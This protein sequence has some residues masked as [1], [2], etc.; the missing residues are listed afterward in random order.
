MVV[1]GIIPFL[2]YISILTNILLIW[3]VMKKTDEMSTLREDT[4]TIFETVEQFSDHLDNLHELETFYGD[5]NL[6]SL[7]THSREV[8]NNIIDVQE[9]YYDDVETTL[10]TYDEEESTEEKE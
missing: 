6:Q 3:F 4:F 10:E 1:T 7:M 9:K 8:I 2:L 5:Q